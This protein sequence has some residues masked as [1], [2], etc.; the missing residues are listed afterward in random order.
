VQIARKFCE[1]LIDVLK[2]IGFYGCK[3]DP[4]LWTQWNEKGKRMLI[5]GIYVDDCL[6]I[7]KDLS[8]SCLFTE[9]KKYVLNLKIEKEL[10]RRTYRDLTSL[11]DSFDSKLW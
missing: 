9:L 10:G 8:I 4:C 11:A 7:G 2:V 1:K 5:V 6:T 3:C